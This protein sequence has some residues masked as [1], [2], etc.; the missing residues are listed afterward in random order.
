[1]NN[2]SQTGLAHGL[3]RLLQNQMSLARTQTSHFQLVKVHLGSSVQTTQFIQLLGFGEEQ[4]REWLELRAEL[5]K[6]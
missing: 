3:T 5:P 2:Y 1:M 4:C 6:I